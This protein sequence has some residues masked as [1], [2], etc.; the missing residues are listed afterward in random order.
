M[1]DIDLYSHIL[2][3]QAPWGVQDV[4]LDQSGGEVRVHVTRDEAAPLACP[5]CGQP[6]SGYDTR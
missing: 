6:A 1:R 2:N 4:E 3:I 5:E